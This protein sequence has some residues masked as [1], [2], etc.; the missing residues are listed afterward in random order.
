MVVEAVVR[1]VGGEPW[2]GWPAEAEILL[3]G[4]ESLVVE[5]SFASAAVLLR[6]LGGIVAVDS[7]LKTRVCVD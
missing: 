1:G 2:F 4:C 6:V 3:L 5:D 7:D